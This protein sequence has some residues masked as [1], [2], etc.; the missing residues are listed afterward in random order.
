MPTLKTI[1][2]K[3]RQSRTPTG[4]FGKTDPFLVNAPWRKIR[5]LK[6]KINPLCEIC[7]K[8]DKITPAKPVDH[9]KSRKLWPELKLELENLT[10]MCDKHHNQK[11]NL[12]RG[13]HTK[14]QWH[15]VFDNHEVFGK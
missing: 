13:L 12:E 10:S 4:N 11:S 8:E 15:K 2:R 5:K 3:T 6:L 14:G 1:G 9:H 7:L